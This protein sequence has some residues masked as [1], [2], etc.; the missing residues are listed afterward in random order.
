MTTGYRI[1]PL[2]SSRRR[3]SRGAGSSTQVLHHRP[4][5]RP[6]VRAGTVYDRRRLRQ[7]LADPSG[8]CSSDGGKTWL[9]AAFVGPDLGRF[10]W[11]QFAIPLRMAP[12]NYVLASRAI[13]AAGAT[14]PEQRMENAH[15]YGNNSWLDHAVKVAVA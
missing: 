15:G 5:W 13:D 11:R 14:Q 7:R 8:G 4:G 1:T 3:L 12:G 10:A 2:A 6:G 9:E